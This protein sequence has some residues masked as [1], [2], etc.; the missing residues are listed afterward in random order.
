MHLK[1][2]IAAILSATLCF[3]ANLH[4]SLHKKEAGPG[5][6]LLVI[7][8]IHGDEPG[9]YLAPW[10]FL[11]HYTVT[12][13]NVWVVPN[14]NFDAIVANKRGPYG[15]MNRKFA[16]IDV[17]DPDYAIVSDIKKIITDPK[18]NLVL[19]LHDGHGFYRPVHKNGLLNPSA[20]GQA[21]IIDQS[22]LSNV[23][24]G[25]L[26]GIA[27]KV[28]K[29]T[30]VSLIEDVHEFNVKNTQTRDKDEAMRQSLTYFAINQ[31]K[32]AFAVETSKNIA[33]PATKVLYQLRTL[34]QF[35]AIVGI[36]FKK[37][38]ELNLPTIRSKLSQIGYIDIPPAKIRL[39]LSGIKERLG[40][41]PVSDKRLEYVSDNPLVAAVKTKKEIDIYFGSKKLST[42]STQN[43]SFDDSLKNVP[44]F[45]DGRQTT[46]SVGTEV[47]VKDFVKFQLPS[48]YRVNIIGF[49][50]LG[51][52][53]ENGI[54]V[55]LAQIDKRY[56][57]DKEAKSFRAE[58]YSGRS[59]CGTVVVR[60][61]TKK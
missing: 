36:G 8:G 5:D 60:F 33:D 49:S 22:S 31:K 7:G 15:D 26:A 14:L 18:V 32:P 4:F 40:Y 45:I 58:M 24:Y 47:S 1:I 59:F 16:K 9:G 53:N 13:G 37:D 11:R 28:S 10:L 57:I 3:G 52:E 43:F 27:Q 46:V 48:E 25:D 23:K 55:H 20:W 54:E 44:V 30:S 56:S 34:E 51:V 29:N 17:R 35:M 38:I 50:R 19:N 2:I 21:C 12:R 61:D 39:D 42:L 41:F 6:T